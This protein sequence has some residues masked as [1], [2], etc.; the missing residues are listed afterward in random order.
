M[1]IH[2][3]DI[4]KA[5]YYTDKQG[6]MCVFHTAAYAAS[7]LVPSALI[8]AIVTLGP[9]YCED[10][11]GSHKRYVEIFVNGLGWPGVHASLFKH[12]NPSERENLLVAEIA[13]LEQVIEKL[14]PDTE[15][16]DFLD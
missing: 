6:F 10:P 1:F 16:L 8:D 14:L 5:L 9:L 7:S 3:C 11:V 13:R 4:R 2:I 12:V 15:Y